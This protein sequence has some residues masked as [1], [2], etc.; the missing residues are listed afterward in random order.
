MNDS[1]L[2]LF[3]IS[4]SP[5]SWRVMLALEVK[6]IDYVSKRLDAA[7][8]EQKTAQFLAL[9]PRGK[10]PVI[11]QGN[12]VVRESIA[13][14]TYLEKKFPQ[15]AILGVDAPATGAIWQWLMDFDNYLH[16]ALVTFAQILFRNQVETREPELSIAANTIQAE[17]E[18]IEECLTKYPYLVNN[19][20]STAD[21]VLYPEIQWIKRAIYQN[22]QS[23]SAQKIADFLAACQELQRWQKNVESLPNFE[24]TYPPH[25]RIESEVTAF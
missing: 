14:I 6:G 4:G 10:V 12:L 8:K 21:I 25:W 13:I 9:N 22:F 19:T 17:V 18:K 1:K 16:P 11:R 2:E 15:P 7:Q 24:R 3:W 5:P 23:I 20:L